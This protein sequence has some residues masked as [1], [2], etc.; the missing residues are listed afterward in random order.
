MARSVDRP[1]PE[2]IARYRAMT[3]ASGNPSGATG[4]SV[5][6]ARRANALHP[7]WTDAPMTMLEW[8]G[9]RRPILYRPE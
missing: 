7:D 2:P 5:G 1:S 4:R 8:H 6:C 3:R 9:K